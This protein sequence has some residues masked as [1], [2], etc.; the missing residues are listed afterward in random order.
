LSKERHLIPCSAGTGGISAESTAEMFIQNVIRLHGLPD[1]VV[2]DR[3]TQ[4]VARFWRR[5]C[6]ILGITVKPLTVFHPETDGQTEA[7]NKEMERYLRTYVSYQQDD[8]VKW[9]PLAEFAANNAPSATTMVSPFFATRGYDPRMSFDFSQTDPQARHPKDKIEL[10]RA[11]DTAKKLHDL[12]EWLQEQIGLAQTR[13]E[14]FADQSRKPAPAYKVGDKVYLSARNIKT[15]RP[16]KKL[17]VKNL[18]PFEVLEKVGPTSYRLKL[19]EGMK[20]HPVFHSNLLRLDPENPLPGQVI[21]PPEPIEIDG[22]PEYE[23]EKVLDSRIR[24]GR[25]QYKVAWIGYPPDSSWYDADNLAN[26]PDAV[27]EFHAA[28]PR[29]PSRQS[30][31]RSSA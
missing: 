6:K 23:V 20:I 5:L 14:H 3:G 8:W 29:K 9:L 7:E 25:V 4:F 24:H 22:E 17:D 13:M 30:P 16:S 21:A 10:R 28:Y 11:L 15:Q 2:S 27:R 1:T 12:W 19:D 31:R 26:S 18:G